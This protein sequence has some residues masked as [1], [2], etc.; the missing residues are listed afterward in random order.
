M[1]FLPKPLAT[2]VPNVAVLL[3]T[4]LIGPKDCMRGW[5][6]HWKQVEDLAV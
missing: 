2:S 3:A 4:K 5:K 6:K 1:G